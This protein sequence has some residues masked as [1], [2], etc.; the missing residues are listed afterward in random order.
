MGRALAS[1]K[2][3]KAKAR[4]IQSIGLRCDIGGSL[5]W[6][7][8]RAGGAGSAYERC[9][10]DQALFQGG[11]LHG[12]GPDGLEPIH[13]ESKLGQGSPTWLMNDSP[14]LI[15]FVGASQCGMA[16]LESLDVGFD[17]A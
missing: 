9:A 15:Q 2:N 14:Q 16:G 1:P 3:E 12:L 4:P 13:E 5:D 8:L 10:L 7:E 17:L 11:E 6:G